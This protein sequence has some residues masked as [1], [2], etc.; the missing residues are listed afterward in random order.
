MRIL[1]AFLCAAGMASGAIDGTV[2]NGT[3]GKVQAGATVTLYKLSQ[4]GLEQVESV[5]S[6]AQ[7]NFRI[8]AALQ[9]PRLIQTAY[10]GVTYNH[11]LPPGSPES[12]LSLDVYNA[13]K[14]PG[15]AAI[16]QH[17]I[18]LEPVRGELLVNETFV[19]QNDGKTTYNDPDGGTLK[20]FLPPEAKGA[21][22]VN[23]TAPQGMPIRRAA[24]KTSSP[25]VYKVDF[26]IKPGETH[27]V[28]E[29]A[30]PFA[31]GETFASKVLHKDGA[32]R[33]VVPAGVTVTGEGITAVGV[34]PRTQAAI[35]D[36]KSPEYKIQVAG[37]GTLRR[38]EPEAD[39]ADSGPSFEQIQPKVYGNMTWI[40]G[41]TLTIL[42]L[43]F[44][45]LYR[46]QVPAKEKNE[47]RRG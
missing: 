19:F 5:K 3:T 41:L 13:S 11:M 23:A 29:Y 9:G 38:A 4:N 30:M 14:R 42:A 46:A 15:A 43:G 24:D 27:I 22:Q 20:F 47:R 35:F 39:D 7:G 26:P 45:L 16:A 8:A 44:V 12:G 40:L 17:M 10:D 32:T 25:N 28:V 2:L 37:T 6:D 1:A 34:E 33:L 31:T 18:L 36:V 21:M